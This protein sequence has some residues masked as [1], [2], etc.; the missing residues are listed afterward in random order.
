MS[1]QDTFQRRRSPFGRIASSYS[2][3]TYACQIFGDTEI[4][5]A[6]DPADYGLASLV[7]ISAGSDRQVVAIVYDTI[8]M[9]P[10]FG[11]LGPRL[12]TD[13]DLAVFSPDYLS[14]RVTIVSLLTLGTM[15]PKGARQRTPRVAP[16][17]DARVRAL[18]FDEVDR[19]HHPG[20][21]FAVGYLPS[22]GMLPQ[23]NGPVVMEMLLDDLQE[24]FPEHNRELTV[25][26]QALSWDNRV[27]TIS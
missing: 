19:F 21:A 18:D 25:L 17:L 13:S 6:P 15:T 8:L 16:M 11:Q 3:T 9:N 10:D 5:Q 20:G 26:S 2:H 14:E 24:R 4:A 12:S 1:D 7:G 27:Q 23:G 22:M